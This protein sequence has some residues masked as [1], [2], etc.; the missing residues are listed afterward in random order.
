MKNLCVFA[1]K[2]ASFAGVF[3]ALPDCPLIVY[4]TGPYGLL[5]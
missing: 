1:A 5:R 4:N 2:V 3:F